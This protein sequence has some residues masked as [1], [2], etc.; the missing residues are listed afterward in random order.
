MFVNYGIYEK[1]DQSVNSR[2]LVHCSGIF[3]N[4]TFSFY[5]HLRLVP[6]DLNYTKTFFINA[7]IINNI[8]YIKY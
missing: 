7:T 3:N 6:P 2:L 4:Q 1:Y 5:L 8:H